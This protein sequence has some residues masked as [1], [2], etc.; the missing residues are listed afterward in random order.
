MKLFIDSADID[1]VRQAVK[2]GVI[3]GCTTNPKLA[4]TAEPGDFQKRVKEILSIVDGPVSVEVVAD[5]VDGMLA[6]AAEYSSWDPE[7]VV[8]KIPMCMEGL[9]VIHKLENERDVR[10]NVTC[11]MNSNQAAMALMAGASYVSL[12][13]GR[14]TDMGY[15]ADAT[16][17]ETLGFIERGGF[18]AE[19]IAASM[20][21][22]ADI[23]RSFLAGAHIVTTPYKFLPAMVHHPRTVETIQEFK[24]AWDSAKQSGGV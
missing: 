17:A 8:V 23:Q 7:N 4:A 21:G 13:V 14:I 2:L 16:L 9:E 12:F 19:I 10:V 11:M 5:D 3:S 20:R 6:E 18:D 22:I 1:E 24:D 15:D